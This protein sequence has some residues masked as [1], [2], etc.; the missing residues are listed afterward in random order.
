MAVTSRYLYE[1]DV[2]EVFSVGD[3]QAAHA[4]SVPVLLHT[5]VNIGRTRKQ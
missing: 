5:Y 4:M 2:M 1:C 3:V